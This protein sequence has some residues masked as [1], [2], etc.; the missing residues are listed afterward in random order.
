MPVI[1]AIQEADVRRIKSQ[2]QPGKKVLKTPSQWKKLSIMV[3]SCH[4]GY[5]RKQKIGRL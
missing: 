5:K 1:L 4:R 2:G 3:H